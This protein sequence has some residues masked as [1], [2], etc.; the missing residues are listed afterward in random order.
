MD[1]DNGDVAAIRENES[2]DDVPLPQNSDDFGSID[3]CSDGGSSSPSSTQLRKRKRLSAVLDKISHHLT[4]GTRSKSLDDN[5]DAWPVDEGRGATFHDLRSNGNDESSV[6]S[7]LVPTEGTNDNGN[8]EPTAIMPSPASA[9]AASTEVVSK[10]APVSAS[11]QVRVTAGQHPNLGR[12]R[13]RFPRRSSC[14]TSMNKN[15]KEIDAA[16]AAASATGPEPMTV[17]NWDHCVR[18]AVQSGQGG[19]GNSGG[20]FSFLVSGDG[21]TGVDTPSAEAAS[22]EEARKMSS[23]A[24][25]RR[26][27]WRDTQQQSVED[28]QMHASSQ[29]NY[30]STRGRT[31]SSN[32]SAGS[33]DVFKFDSFDRDKY[34]SPQ[35]APVGVALRDSLVE[36]MAGGGGGGVVASFSAASGASVTI[37]P[38]FQARSMTEEPGAKA[39]P[40]SV[41]STVVAG[42]HLGASSEVDILFSSPVSGRSPHSSLSSPQVSVD[43]PR[44]CFS[45]LRIKDSIEEADE[46][47]Y[48]GRQRQQQLQALKGKAH[49][50]K[51]ARS[52]PSPTG[53]NSHQQLILQHQQQHVNLPKLSVR[54]CEDEDADGNSSNNDRFDGISNHS[55]MSNNLAPTAPALSRPVSPN[56]SMTPST[57][58][59]PS[60]PRHLKHL[61]AYLTDFYRRRCLSDTDLSASWEDLTKSK[62]GSMIPSSIAPSSNSTAASTLTTAVTCSRSA[63]PFQPTSGTASEVPNISPPSS[64]QPRRLCRSPAAIGSGSSGRFLSLP[65]KKGGSLESETSGS[66]THDI[67]DSPLDLSVKSSGGNADSRVKGYVEATSTGSFG[68]RSISP[69][70][71]NAS[72]IAGVAGPADCGLKPGVS[73]DS[74]IMQLG[75]GGATSGSSTGRARGKSLNRSSGRTRGASGG[76]SMDRFSLDR[77]DQGGPVVE[78]SSGS[79]NDVAYPCPVCGQIFGKPVSMLIRNLLCWHVKWIF[80]SHFVA[81]QD[82]LAKHMASRH[83]SRSTDGCTGVSGGTGVSSTGGASSTSIGGSQPSSSSKAFVCDVCKRCFARSGKANCIGWGHRMSHRKLNDVPKWP[84][85]PMQPLRH[86][87]QFPVRHPMSPPDTVCLT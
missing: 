79:N 5:R 52:S 76:G 39:I 57:P 2:G 86:I 58:I 22:L 70:C 61:P 8:D 77:L 44:I 62:S 16:A 38:V 4:T 21:A 25:L 68:A 17:T 59:S 24:A 33:T 73:M 40:V 1:E 6:A 13:R 37:H 87:I 71:G 64:L 48:G 11:L 30:L 35:K 72:R 81:L 14:S 12:R 66:S 23:T 63:L 82:R 54:G 69:G 45:P 29:R 9:A 20:S 18:N 51:L 31:G 53:S 83:K 75:I 15:A 28:L 55:R 56:S 26:E 47:Q 46:D 32:S 34:C 67:Q 10:G 27:Q 50:Q 36:S 80:F 43:S 84:H 42:S 19:G 65:S 85:W 41:S 74:V 7:S 3:N 60:T 78:S 49:Q